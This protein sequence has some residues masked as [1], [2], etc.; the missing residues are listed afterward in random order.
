M[1]DRVQA[2]IV[3]ANANVTEVVRESDAPSEKIDVST[4]LDDL[5][6]QRKAEHPEWYADEG[7][8][9]VETQTSE[10]EGT[11]ESAEEE[12]AEAEVEAAEPEQA[13]ATDT[14]QEPESKVLKRLLDRERK[15][16]ED[17]DSFETTKKEYE[18][19]LKLYQKAQHQAKSNPIQFLKAA[20][21]SQEELIDIAKAAYYESL[22]DLAPDDYKGQKELQ[23]LRQEI[24][25]LK[26]AREKP[27]QDTQGNEGMHE[28]I[29]AY[30][31]S[32]LEATKTFDTEAFPAVA[33]VVDAYSEADVA[34]DMFAV[35]QAYAEEQQ[36]RGA[37][38]S[39]EQCLAEV[40]T[41]YEKLLGKMNPAQEAT[42]AQS[43]KPDGKKK[44]NKTLS[45]SL[46][47]NV[48]QEKSMKDMSYEEIKAASR[49]K[50][51]KAMSEGGTE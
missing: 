51:F 38:L 1:S 6:A 48:P 36:G 7:E 4:A 5:V 32:M 13:G 31:E 27:P 40:N 16:R 35:A 10:S 21:I 24:A 28:A 29:V 15:L 19:Q 34:A 43:P 3:H 12:T 30:Q 47:S 18:D 49:A 11:E 14:I 37:P 26:S 45:N 33:R 17:K 22:G 50:F 41:R 20:G 2:E 39:P 44:A 42:P 46:S 25:E 8:A 9:A 23:E